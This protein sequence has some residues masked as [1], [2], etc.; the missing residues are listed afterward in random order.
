MDKVS[1]IVPAYNSE[2]TI[3]RCLDSILKQTY[4]NFEIIVINDGS[5]DRTEEICQR[6]AKVNKNV[7]IYTQKNQGVSSARNLGIEKSDGK[8]LQFVDSDDYIDSDMIENMVREIRDEREWVICGCIGEEGEQKKEIKTN[9]P[10]KMNKEETLCALMEPDSIRGYLVNKLFNR[11]IIW[12]NHLCMR[13]D[14]SVCEDLI[15][16]LEYAEHIEKAIYINRPMYHYVYREDSV[17]HKKYSPK[18]FSVIHGFE[19]IK[20]ITSKY[21]SRQLERKVEAHYLILIIQLFVMLKRNHYTMKT[22]EMK[23]VLANMRARKLV[24]WGTHWDLK[25]KCACIPI[26]ILSILYR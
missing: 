6:Y 7:R 18:R 13:Q 17:T 23:M 21:N 14:V 12:E 20:E 1:V 15:F 16:C 25:Y 19:V 4:S 24:L 22:K 5:T 26:K 3:E 11:K 8:Y 10:R 9:A 2:E